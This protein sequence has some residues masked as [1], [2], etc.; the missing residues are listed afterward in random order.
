LNHKPKSAARNGQPIKKARTGE[1][2]GR[3]KN[4]V[5]IEMR[6]IGGSPAGAQGRRECSPWVLEDTGNLGPEA[7]STNAGEEEPKRVPA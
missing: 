3:F 1:A 2:T 7:G 6:F 4:D 5:D